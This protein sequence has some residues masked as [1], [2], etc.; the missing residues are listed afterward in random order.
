MGRG[1]KLR[2]QQH[3]ANQSR[4]FGGQLLQEEFIIPV[5]YLDEDENEIFVSDDNGNQVYM[6]D[7]VARNRQ[8]KHLI[9]Y[10]KGAEF[11]SYGFKTVEVLGLERRIPKRYPV[12]EVWV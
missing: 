2:M 9:A 11:F 10:L 5:S 1:I 8:K 3:L 6:L 7:K 12:A 4:S